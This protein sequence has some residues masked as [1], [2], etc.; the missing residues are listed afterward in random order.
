[1]H[2]NYLFAAEY[3]QSP[4]YQSSDQAFI[5]AWNAAI[6]MYSAIF[7]GITLIATTGDGLPDFSP[8]SPLAVTVPRSLQP[9]CVDPDMDCGAQ[10]TIVSHFLDPAVGGSNA[11]AVEGEGFMAMSLFVKLDFDV[12]GLKWLAQATSGTNPVL[13]GGSAV[14]SRILCGVEDGTSFST[15]EMSMGCLKTSSCPDAEA[16][17]ERCAEPC[18]AAG[19]T[20]TVNCAEGDSG[21]APSAEQT[22]YNM[23]QAYFDQTPFAAS[24]GMTAGQGL[25]NFYQIYAPDIFY[26]QGMQGCGSTNFVAQENDAGTDAGLPACTLADPGNTIVTANGATYTTDQQLLEQASGLILQMAEAPEAANGSA[27]AAE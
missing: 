1:M 16:P 19:C 9:E 26:A 15:Q 22:L 17:T 24:F 6:D 3:G 25:L 2:W 4:G 12:T 10:A 14:V 23:M 18:T 11:K 21:A 20:V 13:N 27:G 8:A 7:R 5:D